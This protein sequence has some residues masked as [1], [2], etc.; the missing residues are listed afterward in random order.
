MSMVA[1]WLMA[2]FTEL[3]HNNY[4]IDYLSLTIFRFLELF[5]PFRGLQAKHRRRNK[6]TNMK[7]F[8]GIHSCNGFELFCIWNS[9]SSHSN[10]CPVLHSSPVR[11]LLLPHVHS[12]VSVQWT[13]WDFAFCCNHNTMTF[14]AT[15]FWF[16][17]FSVQKKKNANQNRVWINLNVNDSIYNALVFF[18]SGEWDEHMD[19]FAGN[20]FQL[21]FLW[22][23]SSQCVSRRNV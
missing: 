5:F 11:P 15:F 17:I 21:I 12:L 9:H 4:H 18:D 10:R 8:V 14:T 7:F 6:K 19:V 23:L 20:R 1:G 2:T 22:F 16:S 13:L 3:V